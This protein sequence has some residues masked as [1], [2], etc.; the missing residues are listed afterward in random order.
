MQSEVNIGMIGHVDH[1]KTSLTRALS[2]KWTSAHS[3]ELK[4]GI[5]IRIG[6]A[7]AIFYKTPKGKGFFYSIKKDAASKVARAVSFLDAPGHETLMTTTIAASSIIDGAVLVIAANE[8]CPQPQT[9]EHLM[10]LDILGIQNVVIVQNKIDLVS[11]EAALANYKQIREFLKGTSAENAPIIP[12]SANYGTNIDALIEAIEETIPTPKR[13][14]SS[15]PRMYVTRSFDINKPG[16]KISELVGGVIGGSLLQGKFHVG[17]KIELRPGITKKT[18]DKE[19]IIP[20]QLEITG[21]RAGSES[22][23]EVGPGGLVSIE[24]KLDPS[25]AKG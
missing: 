9:L 22:V 16:T 15:T 24:T 4:R 17:D 5:T 13:D 11:R 20:I 23:E 18:K 7:D 25:L 2:G 8:K 14:V 21:L 1:G 10:V 3:E 6:Y 12:V 19:N